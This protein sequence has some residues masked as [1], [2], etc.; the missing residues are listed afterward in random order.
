MPIILASTSPRRIE[1]M[2]NAGLKVEVR[3]PDADETPIRGEKP[4]AL[5][6]R[7]CLAKALS[8]AEN[9]AVSKSE[10]V[11]AADT[12]VV[13][14][15]GRQILGKPTS[16]RDAEKMLNALSG[17]WHTVLTGYCIWRHDKK[18]VRVVTSKVKMRKL[19]KAQIRFYIGTGE[20]MD[21]AGSYAAQG[22]GM[23]LVESIRG[24]YT[25]VVGL[26]MTQLLADLE[27]RF[28]IPFFAR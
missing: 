3:K 13:A 9:R 5:V 2:S 20:P 22:L 4:R 12:I 14:P 16:A 11:V 19:T 17:R 8:A 25:N 6:R 18:L 21:K 24:S 1:L 23:A 26:P 7:L 15:N 27:Q 28:D 10:I